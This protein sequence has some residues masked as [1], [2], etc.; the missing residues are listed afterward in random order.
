VY[1][2]MFDSMDDV[3]HALFKEKTQCKEKLFFAVKLAWETLYTYYA[4]VTQTMDMIH[5]SAHIRDP[6]RKLRLI[7]RWQK[8]MNIN[9]EYETF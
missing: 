1:N 9:P 5:I 2:D 4:E 3:M 6:F 7:Q 8:G